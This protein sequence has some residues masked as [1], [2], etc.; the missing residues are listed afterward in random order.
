[1]RLA[2]VYQRAN[3]DAEG[4]RCWRA[5][6]ATKPTTRVAWTRLGMVRRN[7]GDAPGARAAFTR[8]TEPRAAFERGLV[9]LGLAQDKDLVTARACFERALLLEPDHAD[10]RAALGR[11]LEGDGDLAAAEQAYRRAIGVNPDSA[12]ALFALAEAVQE[13]PAPRRSAARLR[14]R[15]RAAA[16][17]AAHSRVQRQRAPAP[18]ARRGRAWRARGARSCCTSTPSRPRRR[19]CSRSSRTGRGD[20]RRSW[21]PRTRWVVLALVGAVLAVYAQ[22]GGFE[23]V[24][25]DDPD[26][27]LENP[28]VRGGLSFAGVRWAFSAA[29]LELAPLDVAGAHAGRAAVR[30]RAGGHHWMS[31]AWHALAA[32]LCYL[33]LQR[34]SARPWESAMVAFL[35]A[36]HPLRVESVAWISERKDVLSGCAFFALLLAYARHARAPSAARYG[37]VLLCFALGLLAK[38]MLVTAPC[39]CCCSTSG[40]WRAC[41]RGMG[42]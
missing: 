39:V 42:A 38:P 35:F 19:R 16:R 29:T 30:A 37:L 23:F 13:F 2:E 9:R 24:R 12:E 33:A 32:V 3:Q 5:R 11:L 21:A 7:L 1:V 10:A 22:V 40:R 31:V 18:R 8:A 6:W 25:Y 4:A 15:L 34:L 17:H 41:A 26:Y 20:E 36:L 14:S 27:V 28:A